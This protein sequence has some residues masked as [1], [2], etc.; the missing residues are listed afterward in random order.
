MQKT[1]Q[2]LELRKDLTKL[3]KK[4][5][6]MGFFAY[7]MNLTAEELFRDAEFGFKQAKRVPK[8]KCYPKK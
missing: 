7:G 2:F 5:P 8:A 1:R 3:K 4:Y 6:E